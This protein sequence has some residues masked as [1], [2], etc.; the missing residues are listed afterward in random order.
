MLLER[1]LV[2]QS[3]LIDLSLT[4]HHLH[5]RFDDWSESA[6]QHHR[7]L[8]VFQ[9]NRSRSAAPD[10]WQRGARAGYHPSEFDH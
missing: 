7:N 1:E 2:K 4:H 8:R 6:K 3:T 10:V 9:Q 5:S